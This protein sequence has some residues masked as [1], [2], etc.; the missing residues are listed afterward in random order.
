MRGSTRVPVVTDTTV[1]TSALRG[2]PLARHFITFSMC[3]SVAQID[4]PLL[5]PEA[6][7][8]GFVLVPFRVRSP[9]MCVNM[10]TDTDSAF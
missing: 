4:T 2:V 1:L 6:L 7:A 8:Y 9:Y 5:Q 10:A 3:L